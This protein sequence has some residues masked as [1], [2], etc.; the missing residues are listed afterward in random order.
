MF[1]QSLLAWVGG[2]AVLMGIIGLIGLLAWG[3]DIW[4]QRHIQKHHGAPKEDDDE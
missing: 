3:V 4:Y 2:T 1:P